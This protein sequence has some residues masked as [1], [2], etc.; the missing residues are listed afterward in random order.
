MKKLFGQATAWMWCILMVFA[1]VSSWAQN[2]DNP[3]NWFELEQGYLWVADTEGA[4][5][6]QHVM[7]EDVPWQI[8]TSTMVNRGYHDGAIWLRFSL[9]TTNR[10][11]SQVYLELATPFVDYI[12]L[13]LVDP[14]TGQ[15]LLHQRSGDHVAKSTRFLKHRYPVFPL[16][17]PAAGKYHIYLHLQ[18]TSSFMFPVT[19]MLPEQFVEEEMG[20]QIFYGNIFGMLL[21]LAFYNGIVWVFI[22]EKAYLYNA[23]FVIAATIYQA[24]ISGIGNVYVWQGN[25][26]VNDKILMVSTIVSVYFAGRF[27]SRFLELRKHA[28]LVDRVLTVILAVFVFMLIPALLLQERY[29]LPLLSVMELFVCVFAIA[30]MILLC[31]NGN[32]WARHL[33]AGWS[34]LIMGTIVFV[35][36]NLGMVDRNI[37]VEY[38]HAGGMALG[39]V[40]VTSALAARLGKERSAKNHALSQ[41][42]ELAQ[43]VADLNQEKEQLAYSANMELERR[44]EQKTQQLH[45]M[46]QELKISNQQLTYATQTDALTG[47]GNRRY[48]DSRFPEL[49]KQCQQHRTALGILVIDADHFK[50]I[51]DKYGHLVGDQ[52][53]KKLATILRRFS[54]RDL[55]VLVRYG[56]EE[57]VLLLTATDVDGARNVA[58]AIRNYVENSAFWVDQQKLPVTVSIGLH[59]GIPPQNADG[60]SLLQKADKALY[61]AKRN[62]RNRVELHEEC[63]STANA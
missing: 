17:I 56:G 14:I 13:H 53:L 15:E 57:F 27:A 16:Q 20:R 21:V 58:E 37:F 46:L 28:P 6:L 47:I 18:S 59:V 54:R 49:I 38:M 22:R 29:V 7:A 4:S 33:L 48:L 43:E 36:S 52:C 12:D 19:L 11:S 23:V 42:L 51:N 39:N 10:T 63:S 41:A 44:V 2:L 60:D 24:C 5:G 40:M 32:Y 25:Y 30:A 35:F 61:A 50:Q 55:D 26:I 31:F 62:G 34:I 9:N 45:G 8:S 3:S 1:S